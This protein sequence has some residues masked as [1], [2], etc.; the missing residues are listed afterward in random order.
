MKRWISATVFIIASLLS[1]FV[2]NML[3]RSISYYD[4]DSLG[5]FCG[6]LVDDPDER[7]YYHYRSQLEKLEIIPVIHGD[8]TC[9]VLFSGN[10][11]YEMYCTWQDTDGKKVTVTMSPYEDMDLQPQYSSHYF[12]KGWLKAF[13]ITGF[14]QADNYAYIFET[15]DM[16]YLVSSVGYSSDEAKEIFCRIIKL[17]PD[18]SILSP[19]DGMHP[20]QWYTEYE[21]LDQAVT[22]ETFGPYVPSIPLEFVSG[23]REYSVLDCTNG[24]FIDDMFLNFQSAEKECNVHISWRSTWGKNG[25][26]GS[27]IEADMLD[28]DAVKAHI[29]TNTKGTRQ[30]IDLGVYSG[31]VFVYI[32]AEGFEPEDILD[33]LLSVP[34]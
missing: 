17:R 6:V 29:E 13:S 16:N 15:D 4:I 31:E 14:D 18:F 26:A 30:W 10:E 8:F 20:V 28:L 7:Y 25:F 12:Q 3:N 27:V 24:W 34:Q 2:G 32:H 19:D 23:E 11:A 21:T 1:L 5:Y 22:D 33:M 9:K